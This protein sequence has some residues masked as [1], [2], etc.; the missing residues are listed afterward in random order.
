MEIP[1]LGGGAVSGGL[2]NPDTLE[3]NETTLLNKN[4]GENDTIIRGLSDP[5]LLVADANSAG[6]KIGIGTHAPAE[7]L[8]V[9]GN[10]KISGDAGGEG[11]ALILED[12]AGVASSELRH[13]SG[14]TPALSFMSLSS[15]GGIAVSG[16][17]FIGLTCATSVIAQGRDNF[18]VQDAYSP[19]TQQLIVDMIDGEITA[20]GGITLNNSNADKDTQIKGQAEDYLLFVD[21]SGDFVGIKTD[22]PTKSLDINSDSIRLR[23]AKTPASGSDTGD[24]GERC[25]D[26]NYLYQA[27]STDEWKRAELLAWDELPAFAPDHISG[28]KIGNNSSNPAYQLDIAAGEAR[29]DDGTT[30]IIYAGGTIDITTDLDA[31]SEAINT[32]YAIW[33][34]H[35]PT[36]K[37]N[38]VKFSASYTAPTAPSGYTKKRYIGTIRNDGS[39][40]FLGI[41][42]EGTG[43]DRKYQYQEAEG[44]TLSVLSAGSNTAYTDVDCSSILP[45]TAVSATFRIASTI[46]DKTLYV[47][48]NG[49]AVDQAII[50]GET[51]AYRDFVV[52]ANQII[53]YKTLV[54]GS[55]DISVISF[56]EDL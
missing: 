54:G 6:D 7:K 31:G 16:G 17:R 51:F 10:I 53:E 45:P 11:D 32:H 28:L 33:L 20:E 23:I 35:N 47:R 40:D 49:L 15:D 26:A 48:T 41:V 24:Q 9:V 29:S 2:A 46:K 30:N 19:Y 13:T 12:D 38:T 56:R 5:Y 50:D 4:A 25:W 52:D 44:T 22:T 14:A 3:V 39:G 37:A 34:F 27:V 36:T 8:E 55:A 43:R 42:Q 18:V 1:G 21:A